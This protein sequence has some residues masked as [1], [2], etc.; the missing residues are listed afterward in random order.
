VRDILGGE[1]DPADDVRRHCK[2][3]NKQQI[4]GEEIERIKFLSG[5]EFVQN[6]APPSLPR[7]RTIKMEQTLLL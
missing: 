6:T 4:K 1:L 2:T 7:D 5:L 3:S